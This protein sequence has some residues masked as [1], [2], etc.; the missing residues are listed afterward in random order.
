M[1][2]ARAEGGGAG[3]G[4]SAP[5]TPRQP[6]SRAAPD[7]AGG[8]LT[9]SDALAA[10]IRREMDELNAEVDEKIARLEQVMEEEYA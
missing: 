4:G 2:R 6:S 10:T 3:G 7:L 1:P 5:A 8:V 9:A